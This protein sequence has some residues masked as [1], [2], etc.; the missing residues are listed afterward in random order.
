MVSKSLETASLQLGRSGLENFLH[1]TG[2]PPIITS[3]YSGLPQ[4]IVSPVKSILDCGGGNGLYMDMLLDCFPEAEGTLVDSAQF[5]LDQ[6]KAH[7]R[8]KLLLANLED[9]TELLES[10]KTFDLICFSDVLHHCITTSYRKTRDLQTT[11]LKNSVRLLAPNGHFLICERLMNSILTD[12]F[13]TKTIYFLTRLKFAAPFIRSF[14]ANTAGVGVCFFSDKRIRRLFGEADL[15]IVDSSLH[16]QFLK[17]SL[18][19]A[20]LGIKSSSHS[21][22]LLEK[23]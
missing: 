10:G 13:T 5:M 18:K 19:K 14:G 3:F 21:I 22:F 12:E 11:I 23:Q 8:K 1:R 15:R 4:R 2:I 6:N 9:M 20:L 7:K 16:G 17:F